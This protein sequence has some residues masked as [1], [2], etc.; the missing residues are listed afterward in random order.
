MAALT[1]RMLRAAR[2]DA[3]LYEEVEADS[4]ATRQAVVVV[5]LYAVAA[6]IGNLAAGGV[7]GLFVGTLSAL[8]TWYIWA[9]ITYVIGTKLLAEPQTEASMGQLLRTI[10]FAASPG[11]ITVFAF[12]PVL[13]VLIKVVAVIWMLVAMVVGVRQAL[14]YTSTGRAVLVCVIGWVFYLIVSL[15]VAAV[16]G[17]GGVLLGG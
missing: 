16:M 1:T 2:L 3:A 13:G 6:G 14:D 17:I 15:G 10:G 8:V 9:L 5:I 4:S 12:I 7:K 11:I